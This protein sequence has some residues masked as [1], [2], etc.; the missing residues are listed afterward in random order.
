VRG[1]HPFRATRE[2]VGSGGERVQRSAAAPAQGHGTHGRASTTAGRPY[3]PHG[4]LSSGFWLMPHKAG[5]VHVD[6]SERDLGEVERR[7]R[8]FGN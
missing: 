4:A 7:A 2:V 5:A 8:C 6:G 3:T 1:A